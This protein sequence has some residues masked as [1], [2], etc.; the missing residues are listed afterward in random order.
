MQLFTYLRLGVANA[1]NSCATVLEALADVDN[2]FAKLAD[3]E[4]DAISNDVKK[5]FKQLAVRA[6]IILEH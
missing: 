6:W 4:C 2:K 5:W 1:L 3:K